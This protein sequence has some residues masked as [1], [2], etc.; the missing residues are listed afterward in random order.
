MDLCKLDRTVLGE[1][2]SPGLVDLLEGA[3]ETALNHEVIKAAI[4]EPEA[5]IPQEEAPEPIPAPPKPEAQKPGKGGK[6]APAKPAAK[7]KVPEPEP[8][9]EPVIQELQPPPPP[10]LDEYSERIDDIK[11]QVEDHGIMPHSCCCYA[12]VLGSLDSIFI[13]V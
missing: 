6:K 1:H 11:A 10:V 13:A 8:V 5:P 7:S 2:A 4:K 12:Y 3:L 9:V